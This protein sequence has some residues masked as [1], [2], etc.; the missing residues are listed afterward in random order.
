[1]MKH[2][3]HLNFKNLAAIRE[4]GTFDFFSSSNGLPSGTRYIQVV[5]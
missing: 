2:M 1:M 4:K 5:R 3:M